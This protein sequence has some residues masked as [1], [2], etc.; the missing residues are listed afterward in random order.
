MA[1]AEC[2]NCGGKVIVGAKNY[3]CEYFRPTGDVDDCN[4]IVWKNDLD[5]F[6][7]PSLSENEIISLLNGEPIPLVLKSPK[8]GKQF[9]CDGELTEMDCNDGK[10]RWKVRFVFPDRPLQILGE[11]ESDA[12]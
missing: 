10:K 11:G 8:S 3:Y 4:F 6:G 5:K 12:E 7:K 1:K 2:P 9:Q